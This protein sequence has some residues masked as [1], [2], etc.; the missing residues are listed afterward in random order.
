MVIYSPSSIK[1][2]LVGDTSA[3]RS[4]RQTGTTTKRAAGPIRMLPHPA[5]DET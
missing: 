4:L 5:N 3:A 2:G 1:M